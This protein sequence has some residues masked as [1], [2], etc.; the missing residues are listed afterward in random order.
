[1]LAPIMHR[2]DITS[3]SFFVPNR[4]LT[5]LWEEFITGGQDGL[6][7]PVLPYIT[8]AAMSDQSGEAFMYKGTLW[9]YFGLP[10]TT[11]APDGIEEISVL[12]FRAYSKIW[13]DFYRDPNFDDERDLELELAG[14]CASE[15]IAAD[16][17]ELGR[18]GWEK[19]Y[20][21]SALDRTQ[22]GLEVMMPIAATADVVLTDPGGAPVPADKYLGTLPLSPGALAYGDSFNPGVNTGAAQ[23]SVNNVE[24]SLND[25]RRAFAIQKWLEANARG[26]YRYQEQIQVHFNTM[27]PDFRLQRAEYIGG[28]RQPV[29]VSEVLSSTAADDQPLGDMAG[30]GISV[31]SSNHWSYKCLEHGFVITIMSVIPRTAYSQGFERMWT[32]RDKYDF[33][34]TEF[35]HIGEQE[36]LKKELVFGFAAAN[37]TVNNAAFGY[38]PRY[39]EYKF[40]NDRIAGDFRDTLDFWHLGRTFLS[41]PA[42]TSAFTTTFE[43][44]NAGVEDSMRRIFAVQD[45]TDYLW[46]QIS[47][48]LKVRRPLPYFSVPGGL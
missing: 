15:S 39:S 26:G 27:V 4:L 1:M 23:I 30:K 38:I 28:G 22:R 33:A 7:N 20:F 18:R 9:D 34:W 19:D 37:N 8:P 44:G 48:R 13:N 24:S 17:F 29:Q 16:L 36:I 14:E 2:V 6:S 11:G 21:T 42:L 12:P 47:I 5:D 40:K 43:D 10:V 32:R 45:G 3:H 46:F 35:A 41:V 25:L 31:G